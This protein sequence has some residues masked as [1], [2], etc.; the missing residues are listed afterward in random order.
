MATSL[1]AGPAITTE[2]SRFRWLRTGSE[3]LAA[4]IEEIDLA[5][6][7]IRLET[8]IYHAG[9]M[10]DRFL[11]TLV[12]AAQR[13]VKVQVMV[14]ALGS[15]SLPD[16]FWTSLRNAGGE[17]VWFNPL[18]LGRWSYRD[19]RKMLICDDGV[20]FIGGFNIA[21]EYDG[22]G[23][24]KGWRD[25]GLE[26]RG[27]ALVQ[28]LAE[29]FDRFFARAAHK[30]K[31][32]QRFRKSADMTVSGANWTLLLSGPGR[33][34][35][36]LKRTLK[37]DLQ[38]AKCVKIICAY[39]L[40]TWSFRKVLTRVCKRGGRVQLILAGKSD[41]VLSQLASRKLYRNFL[42]S[43]VEIYEYEPQILHAKLFIIDG[44]TY[45]GSANLDVRSMGINYELLVRIDDRAMAA[46]AREIFEEDLKHCKR[47]DP[48]AWRKSRTL[49]SKL[50]ENWAYFV[51]ARLDPFLAR[52]QL[53]ALR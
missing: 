13:G 53:R 43:G 41:V 24:A 36:A 4:M 48:T 14:D 42:R 38:Q 17:C 47:I 9:Q 32:L 23:V 31:R 2:R 7:S 8:Y 12:Q 21:D 18:P 27:G 30:H 22:D 28:A 11:T 46:R 29:S 51:L 37:E 40:P 50:K 26:I 10:G 6:H 34:H 35:G 33:Y 39:F 3:A 16:T 5:R 45:A 1:T 15:F 19:H 52:R 49:W 44:I 20:A 25:L